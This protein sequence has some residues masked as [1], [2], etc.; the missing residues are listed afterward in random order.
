[1]HLCGQT[2]V[3]GGRLGQGAGTK[4]VWWVTGALLLWR[5]IPFHPSDVCQCLEWELSLSTVRLG[6]T[7]A[8]LYGVSWNESLLP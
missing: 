2:L 4:S 6:A 8:G 7:W 1:M 3:Y 5:V